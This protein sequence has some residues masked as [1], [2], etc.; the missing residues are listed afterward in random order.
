MGAFI[1][2]LVGVL[3]TTICYFIPVVGGLAPL[4]GGFVGALSQKLSVGSGILS[5]LYMGIIMI[6]P[7]FL[8][9]GFLI[10]ALPKYG[11]LVGGTLLVFVLILS[12]YSAILGMIGGGIAGI[13]APKKSA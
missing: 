1:A 6:L 3:V 2:A 8:L 10:K 12:V 5:G 13:F 4:L 11:W 9:S 7:A